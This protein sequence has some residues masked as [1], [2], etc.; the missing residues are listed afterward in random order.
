MS[1]PLVLVSRHDV[2]S[3]IT[4]NSP[5][6]RNVLSADMVAALAEA[7]DS[8]EAEDVRCVVLTGAGQAFCAGADLST[9]EAAAAGEFAPVRAVYDG[10]LRVMASPLP[11][12][13]AVNGPAVGAGFNLAL[14]C[15]VRLASPAA[16]FDS[17]FAALRLHPG[18]GH[19]WLL[20]RAVGAQQAMM[21]CLFGEVFGADS[22]R[23]QG[24]VAAVH[25][26]GELVPA[27]VEL[28]SRLAGQSPEF[29][30]RLTDTLRRASGGLS[31]QEVLAEETAAQRWSLGQ[32]EFLAGL[33]EVRSRVL[34][35]RSGQ[36]EPASAGLRLRHQPDSGGFRIAAATAGVMPPL[37][38]HTSAFRALRSQERAS[39]VS[40]LTS[41]SSAVYSITLPTGSVK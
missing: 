23:E 16:C 30:R 29:V 13:G 8:A 31:H 39:Q 38:P 40:S 41:T 20:S 26:A 22:A 18:G 25:P 9:L 24:L 7:Y 5:S 37:V 34:R 4:L 1:E 35:G 6:R 10:F 21:A 14:A 17:R 3:V 28:G 11:T 19:T 2:V 15:D 36:D 27:A 33:S 32:P 12:I